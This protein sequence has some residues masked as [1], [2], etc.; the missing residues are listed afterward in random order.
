MNISSVVVFFFLLC[1]EMIFPKNKKNLKNENPDLSAA[2]QSIVIRRYSSKWRENVELA[3]GLF[4]SDS[5]SFELVLQA[6][7]RSVGHCVEPRQ[8]K[9]SL[10]QKGHSPPP[11]KVP[12]R[13]PRPLCVHRNRDQSSCPDLSSICPPDDCISPWIPPPRT[14]LIEARDG[15]SR[16]P[17]RRQI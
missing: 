17:A 9:M 16:S 7:H 12:G 14:P 10:F 5:S 1:N 13:W 11:R 2:R 4:D 3:A 6:F 8:L 15:I